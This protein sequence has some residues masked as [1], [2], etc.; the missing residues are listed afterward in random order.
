MNAIRKTEKTM[1]EPTGVHPAADILPMMPEDELAQLAEDITANGLI[2]PIVLDADGK[3]VDGRNRLRACE[4]AEVEPRFE[5]LNGKDPTEFVVSANIARRNLNASQRAMALA[6]LYPEPKR[7]RGNK[8]PA[9]KETES[10]SFS[11]SLVKEARII[12][13]SSKELTQDVLHARIHFDVALKQVR[14]AEQRQKSHDFRMA[15]LRSK[16]PDA[17]AL[18]DDGR[19]TIEAGMSELSQRQQ[20]VRRTIEQAQHAASQLLMLPAYLTVI[21][22]AMRLTD[23]DLAMIGLDREESDPLAEVTAKQIAAVLTAAEELRRIKC[24]KGG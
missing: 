10:G 15:E 4:I 20:F 17:A 21:Q 6:M 23:A 5:Q 7:G 19:L 16:A 24:G 3:I 13:G 11:Y 12:L 2:H 22:G 8:D 1:F 9:R 14:E 18:I